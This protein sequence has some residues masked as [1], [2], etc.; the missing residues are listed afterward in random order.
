MSKHHGDPD[1]ARDDW[2]P[3]VP[4]AFAAGVVQ[5]AGDRGSDWLTRLPALARALMRR[6]DLVPEADTLMHGFLGVVLPVR[7]GT[8]RYALKIGLP[9]DEVDNQIASLAVWRGRG[10]V[11][12]ED[13]DAATGAL[14]LERLDH[15]RSLDDIALGDAVDAAAGL[16]RRLAVPAA[17][18]PLPTLDDHVA[19]WPNR[20]IGE[21]ERLGRP[22]PRRLLD[23]AAEVCRALGPASGRLLVDHDLH[24]RNVLAGEREAWLAVDPRGVLGDAEFTLPPLLWNRFVGPEEVPDRIARFID[25]AELDR[26][27]TLGWTLVRVVDYFLWS[28]GMGLTWDPAACRTI[29]DWIVDPKTTVGVSKAG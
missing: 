29:A 16:V 5:H 6:W 12:L 13:A 21:W 11:R 24:F 20:W 8:E 28:T 7:R 17:D 23:A 2:H 22:L 26:D 14:L 27:R 18:E 25:G 19:D 4:D 9:S 3:Q 1:T 15:G 10:M